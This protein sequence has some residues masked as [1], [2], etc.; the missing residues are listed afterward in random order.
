MGREQIQYLIGNGP[1]ISGTD[2]MTS[3]DQVALPDTST[4]LYAPLGTG[5][6]L[7]GG[8]CCAKRLWSW[9]EGYSNSRDWLFNFSVF[10]L[11]TLISGIRC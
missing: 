10:L 2:H 5:G 6:R 1:F 9:G 8:I 11:A 7:S 4:V 3:Y